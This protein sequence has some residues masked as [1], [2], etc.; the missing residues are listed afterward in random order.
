VP[1]AKIRSNGSQRSSPA[2][3][4]PRRESL[5]HHSAGH[6]P[7]R[8]F[9]R[10]NTLIGQNIIELP[11]A[12][13]PVDADDA[14]VDS[15]LYYGTALSEPGSAVMRIECRPY[16][17]SFSGNHR[18][19]HGSTWPEKLF[20]L[21]SNSVSS[22][23]ANDEATLD[24][25]TSVPSAHAQTPQVTIAVTNTWNDVVNNVV[26]VHD[27][28]AIT[29]GS[30]DSILRSSD[31]ALTMNLANGAVKRFNGL[32]QEAPTYQKFSPATQQM[33]V[34]YEVEPTNDLGRLGEIV[35]PAHGTVTTTVTF[36][37]SDPVSQVGDNRKVTVR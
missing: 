22:A 27:S 21:P 24:S 4:K 6:D 36:A 5:V 19:N 23:Q 28:L 10:E 14:A 12:S 3:A 31:L 11:V 33:A 7:L 17:A 29:G 1:S 9:D 20:R 32:H 25:K 13:A 34:A 37:V 18:W 16:S 8:F 30:T 35:V 15:Q 2:E 26:Y